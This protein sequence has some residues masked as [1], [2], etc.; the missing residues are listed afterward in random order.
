MFDLTIREF[1]GE[2]R[3]RDI[4]IAEAL[5]FSRAR[6]FRK[7]ILRCMVAL[8]SFGEVTRAMPSRVDKHNPEKREYWLNEH[9]TF[10]ICTQ[11]KTENA[12]AVTRQIINMFVAWRHGRLAA[13]SE[14][15]AQF[16]VTPDVMDIK[17]LVAEARLTFG[18]QAAQILW[19]KMGLPDLPA[20]DPADPQVVST[21]GGT[22][23]RGEALYS[24]L[25]EECV[26]SGDPKHWTRSRDLFHAYLA[27][28]AESGSPPMGRRAFSN[29]LRGLSGAYRCP[30][31][32]ASFRPA[33]RSDTGYA[34]IY[35][36]AR[37]L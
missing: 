35:L 10:Y 37:T 19:R 20:E 27:F 24:F 31:S 16:N 26:I 5:G 28:C 30:D 23:T 9:Q 7:L 18:R 6:D 32:G 36:I 2:P 4:D 3:M 34:G 17:A 13:P 29:C 21:P 8:G 33:K 22:E 15:S 11:S 12:F 1:D 14:R 25:R